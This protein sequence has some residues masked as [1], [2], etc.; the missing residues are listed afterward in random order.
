MPVWKK[1]I[2]VNA[3]KARIKLEDKTKEELIQEYSKLSEFEKT[4]ILGEFQ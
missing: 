4:E 2:F 1:T 3:I